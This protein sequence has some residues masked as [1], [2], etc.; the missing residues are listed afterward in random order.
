MIDLQRFRKE[1][2]IKQTEIA[3]V[4]GVKQ[5]Y[6]SAIERGA[7]PLNEEQFRLLYNRYG[8]I[9]VPYKTTERPIF[10]SSDVQEKVEMPRE[11]FEKIAQLIDT[12]CSQQGTIAD[13]QKLIT[14]QHRTID[15]LTTSVESNIGVRP[16]E[17]A[18]CADAG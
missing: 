9:L 8:D 14:D 3:E 15:R 13:Q 16:A 6:I 4:L 10:E 5:P 18:G 12:V 11:V 7:R 1:K 17:D 2:N